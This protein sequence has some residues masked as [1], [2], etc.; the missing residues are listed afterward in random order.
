MAVNLS[1]REAQNADMPSLVLAALARHGLQ[2]ADL[3]L[4]LT[5]SVLVE[6]GS[7]TLAQLIAL[8]DGGV[9]IAIDDFGTGYASLRYLAVLPVDA[10]KVDRSFTAGLPTD[11]TS[12]TIVRAVARLAA[13]MGLACIVEGV[14]TE[15]QLNALPPGVRGQGFLLGRPTS[16]PTHEWIRPAG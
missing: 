6:A 14:E 9:K 13:E 3:V 11:A 2:P 10:V 4:E 1:A 15:Q 12:V 5:E 7:D 8:R 16:E